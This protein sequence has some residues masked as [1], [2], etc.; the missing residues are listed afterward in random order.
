MSLDHKLLSIL[1]CPVCKG[2]LIYDRT[3]SELICC[4]DRLAFPIRE[5]IPVMLSDE[6]R[7]L[8]EEERKKYQ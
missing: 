4:V 5:E 1:V 6:A 8:S 2:E 7:S 3:A